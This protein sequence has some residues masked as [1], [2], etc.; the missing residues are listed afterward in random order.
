M[1]IIFAMNMSQI[2][3]LLITTCLIFSTTSNGLVEI[4]HAMNRWGG[5]CTPVPLQS[6]SLHHK[7]TT[8]R[9]AGIGAIILGQCI[10]FGTIIGQILKCLLC[11]TRK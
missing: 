2:S 7:Q 1:A 9:V 4:L 8:R 6:Y 11:N 5:M 3:H 10:I